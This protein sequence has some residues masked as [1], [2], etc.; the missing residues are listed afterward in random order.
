MLNLFT[1]TGKLLRGESYWSVVLTSGKTI[2]EGELSFDFLRGTRSID[3]YLDIA[4]T[5]DCKRIKE[6]TLH[7]PVEN[8]TLAI[9]GTPPEPYCVFQLKRGTKLLNTGANVANAHIIGR[10]DDKAT[11]DCTVV[12]WD[13]I[14]R[15]TY[16][17]ITNIHNFSAWREGVCSVGA[18]AYQYMGVRL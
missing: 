15:R 12:I 13:A 5:E 18:I 11:G 3:W 1:T 8:I 6:I 9:P 10:V 17:H 14:E 16:T 2:T 4:S 7:T